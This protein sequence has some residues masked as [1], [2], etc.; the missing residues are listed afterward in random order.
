MTRRSF[1]AATTATSLLGQNIVQRKPPPAD[2]RIP[3][4]HDPSQFGDLRLPKG[5][6]PHTVVIFIHG[7]FWSSAYTL[8][9][10]AEACAALTRAGA[11]TWNVEYRRVGNAG[12]GW[13]GT[14]EDIVH[15]A[16]QIMRLAERYRF[17]LS[18]LVAA[19]HS[20]GG[21]LLLY[22]TAQRAVDLRGVIPLAAISDL[23]RAWALHLGDG[24]VERFLG[25]SPDQVPQRYRAAS[26]MELLP[27]SV[28]QR[29][30]HGTADK[31]VPFEMS[32]RFARKS[33]NAKLIP[34]K[35]A[36]HFDLIDPQ[37]A[38]WSAVQQNILDWQF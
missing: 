28:A 24:A 2:A 17:D 21:Q 11:V 1:L 27:I 35:G 25:G 6:G 22:L 30:V 20:A 7:G 10:T 18:R 19:G 13:P 38:A 37:S 34:L 12:G 32:E 14:L 4:G 23:R 36:G 31:V 16:E 3:Y 9:S 33:Q 5:A 8:D 15:G 29:V 26:P